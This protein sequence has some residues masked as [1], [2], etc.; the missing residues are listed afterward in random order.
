MSANIA[1]NSQNDQ[2]S[3]GS[4]K[5]FLANREFFVRFAKMIASADNLANRNL[6]NCQ[7]QTEL[8]GHFFGRNIF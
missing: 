5:S 8:F 6:A 2:S 1:N 3:L 4:L 7:R